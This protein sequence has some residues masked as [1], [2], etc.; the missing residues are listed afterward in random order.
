MRTITKDMVDA[1]ITHYLKPE[2]DFDAVSLR[3]IQLILSILQYPRGHW[4]K[5]SELLT[6]RVKHHLAI[7]PEFLK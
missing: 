5:H 3:H 2:P 6:K 4:D 7:V 1:Q